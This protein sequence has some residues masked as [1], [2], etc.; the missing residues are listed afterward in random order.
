[1]MA[2]R[3]GVEGCGDAQAKGRRGDEV[4]RAEKARAHETKTVR[5]TGL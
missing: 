4:R 5:L 3:D 2:M 1:V